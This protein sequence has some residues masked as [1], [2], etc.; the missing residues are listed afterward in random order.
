VAVSTDNFNIEKGK[1]TIIPY[2]QRAEIVANIKFVDKVIPEVGWEQK[3]SDILEYNVDLFAIGDDWSGKFDYLKKY[4]EVT[5]LERTG[6]IS[7]TQLKK[8]L[9]AF[10]VSKEEFV[11]AFEILDQL[12]RDFE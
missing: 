3:V 10:S 11:K 6:G 7:T 1:K 8:T 2:D 12:R 5:Y 9:K 4:C